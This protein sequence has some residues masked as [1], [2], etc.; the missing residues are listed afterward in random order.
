MSER[1]T[2]TREGDVAIVAMSRAD[3]LNALDMAMFE[4]LAAAGESLR[5]DAGLRAVV[6]TGEGEHFCA[7]ID[8]TSLQGPLSDNAGFRDTAMHPAA[9][10][11]ANRFQKAAFVWKELPVPVI[12]AIRGVAYGGGCQVALGAD[13]R[14]AAPD[15]RLSVMEVKWGLIPD[16]ALMA[17][18][19]RLLRMDL[20]K[21]LVLS[22]RV[23]GAE[24]AQRLGLVTRIEADPL[25]AARDEARRIAQRSPDAIRAAKALLERGW[26]AAPADALRLEAELQA[27]ILGMA[28]QQEAVKANLEKRPPVFVPAAAALR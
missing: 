12:A 20:A 19:P 23:V 10:E 5:H 17:S 16:M 28:N 11:I 22:A 7:G 4:A 13:I 21:D 2:I 27:E 15:A 18:L 25:A 1:V 24:E 8:L 6:L 3:K 14:I 9:G 26:A